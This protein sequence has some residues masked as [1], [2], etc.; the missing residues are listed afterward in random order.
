V[1]LC[2]HHSRSTRPCCRNNVCRSV[3]QQRLSARHHSRQLVVDRA[4]RSAGLCQ[5][6]EFDMNGMANNCLDHCPGDESHRPG[7]SFCDVGG[8]AQHFRRRRAREV[9]AATSQPRA[10]AFRDCG[11]RVHRTTFFCTGAI[12]IIP[13]QSPHR[14]PNRSA[15]PRKTAPA[16][17]LLQKSGPSPCADSLSLKI[18]SDAGGN[19]RTANLAVK[20]PQ[21][22]A[23]DLFYFCKKPVDKLLRIYGHFLIF[24]ASKKY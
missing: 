1:R 13:T 7:V 14:P 22:Q 12:S 21:P 5:A 18:H 4:V 24:A 20:F 17:C 9:C 15:S 2:C 23:I 8:G 11:I 19:V 10:A 16:F 6:D 3:P